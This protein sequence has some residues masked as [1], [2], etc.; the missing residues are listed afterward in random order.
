[1]LGGHPHLNICLPL[2]GGLTSVQEY[3]NPV[4]QN[5][6]SKET[7]VSNIPGITNPITEH[8]Y[9]ASSI[10]FQVPFPGTE[11]FLQSGGALSFLHQAL[12]EFRRL[13]RCLTQVVCPGTPKLLPASVSV[14]DTDHGKSCLFCTIHIVLPVSYHDHR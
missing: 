6:G 2:F 11:Q 10:I 9:S 3:R 8:Y 14:K 7:G 12:Y 1:M 13:L 4:C 5:V